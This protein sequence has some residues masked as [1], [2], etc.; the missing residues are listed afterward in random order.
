MFGNN[1]S[2]AS[3]IGLLCLLFGTVAGVTPAAAGQFPLGP[4][5]APQAAA[6]VEQVNINTADAETLASA[7]QGVGPVK[8]ADI[9]AYREMYGD[10]KT[11][12][13]L[14]EVRGIG[15]ATLEQNRHLIT[16]GGGSGSDDTEEDAEQGDG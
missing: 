2:L 12:D 8:A 11:V 14:L 6:A 1:R 16:V 13:E 4:A 10:F 5:P 9:V 3:L 7:L 15:P